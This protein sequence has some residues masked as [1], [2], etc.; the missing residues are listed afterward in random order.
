MNFQETPL[1]RDGRKEE[2]RKKQGSTEALTP[3]LFAL[4]LTQNKNLEAWASCLVACSVNPKTRD[5]QNQ[6]EL[7]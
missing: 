1:Q 6:P 5:G 2:E 3:F 4:F 7:L